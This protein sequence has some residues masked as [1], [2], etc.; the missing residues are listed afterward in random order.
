ME[1]GDFEAALPN[2]Q[3]LATLCCDEGWVEAALPIL[4]KQMVRFDVLS[5]KQ[6]IVRLCAD[7]SFQR[8]RIL[9]LI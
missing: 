4:R 9:H 2:L 3:S 8:V 7:I 5:L 6:H 1:D